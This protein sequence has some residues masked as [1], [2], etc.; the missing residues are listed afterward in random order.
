MEDLESIPTAEEIKEAES[1][2]KTAAH[3]GS[4]M[5]STEGYIQRYNSRG[6]PQN[7]ASEYLRDQTRRAQ[8]SVLSLYGVCKENK[9]TVVRPL[10]NKKNELSLDPAKVQRVREENRVGQRL[11]IIDQALFV[12]TGICLMGIRH[13]LEVSGR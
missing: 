13:R 4:F 2:A 6:Y 10:E 1:E 3:S 12:F 5:P 11:W 9:R 8:N 7:L